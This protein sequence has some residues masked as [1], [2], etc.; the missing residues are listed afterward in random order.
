VQDNS[1][2]LVTARAWTAEDYRDWIADNLLE[3]SARCVA[4]QETRFGG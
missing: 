1:D 3:A 4:G 2:N